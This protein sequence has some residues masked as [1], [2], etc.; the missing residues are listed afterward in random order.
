MRTPKY[1]VTPR[2]ERRVET[3]RCSLFA[4]KGEISLPLGTDAIRSR[5]RLI[6]PGANSRHLEALLGL[7]EVRTVSTCIVSHRDIIFDLFEFISL[8]STSAKYDTVR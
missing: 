7:E 4:D 2:E 5:T 1:T 6:D 3:K 8:Q